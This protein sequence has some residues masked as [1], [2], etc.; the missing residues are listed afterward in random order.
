[1][2]DLTTTDRPTRRRSAP[3]AIALA[4]GAC[5]LLVACDPAPKTPCLGVFPTISGTPA[6]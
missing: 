3:A 6:N 5:G 1:M 4:A 2:H